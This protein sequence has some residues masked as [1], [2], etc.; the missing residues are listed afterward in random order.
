MGFDK[1]FKSPRPGELL[2]SSGLGEHAT[3]DDH[4]ANSSSTGRSSGH[5]IV[6][7]INKASAPLQ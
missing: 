3:G 7:S 6:E 4:L 2:L 1:L 5:R